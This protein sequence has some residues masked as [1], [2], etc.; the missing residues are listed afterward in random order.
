MIAGLHYEIHGNPDGEPLLLSAGL[1]GSGSYW[2]PNLAALGEQYRVIL[3]DH[4]GTGR[5]DRALPDPV[6]VESMADDMIALMDGLGIDNAHVMGHAAGGI[7]GLALALRAPYRLRKLIVVNGW[8][9]ADPQF[10]R[11]FDTRLVL[12]RNSGP[13]A[14]IHA[15]PIFLYPAEW[16]SENSARLDAEEAGHLAHFPGIETMEKRIAALSSFDIEDRLAEIAAPTLAIAAMDDMLVPWTCSARL[17]EGIKGAT[18][19]T[20][21]WG[22]HSC[23]VT[24]PDIFNRN[25][26]AWLGDDQAAGS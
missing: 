1:G 22:A 24:V 15:Q 14:Y 13:L 4:R 25:V 3:Y 26:L 12:L 6:T 17:S 10:L 2:A 19:A 5:S 23:N 18:L 7:A 16:I 9:K 21:P 20:M 8:A 11:C